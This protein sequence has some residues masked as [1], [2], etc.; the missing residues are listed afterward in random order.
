MSFYLSSLMT[1]DMDF[2][3][4][5]SVYITPK[6]LSRAYYTSPLAFSTSFEYPPVCAVILISY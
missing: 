5:V 1:Q 4:I 6:G 3:K 2:W